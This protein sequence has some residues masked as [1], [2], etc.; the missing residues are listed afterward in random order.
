MRTKFLNIC[1]KIAL[2]LSMLFLVLPGQ[3]QAEERILYFISG[4]EFDEDGT[5]SVT[6]I[7]KVNAEHKNINHGIYRTYPITQVTGTT[8]KNYGFAIQSIKMDGE[9][10]KYSVAYGSLNIGVAI[11]DSNK[12]ISVGQHEYEIKYKTRNHV[13]FGKDRDEINFNVTGN[14]WK[15]PIERASF[16]LVIPGGEDNIL[17]TTAFTGAYGERGTDFV[18]HKKNVIRTTRRLEPGEGFTVA[19]AWKKG[20]VAPSEQTHFDWIGANRELAYGLIFV[21]VL[22]YYFL[23]KWRLMR[24]PNQTIIPLFSPPFGMSPGY[25]AALKAKD[26][27]GRV[28]H[29]DI[30][31]AA[32]NGFLHMDLQNRKN[33]VLHRRKSEKKVSPWINK[34]CDELTCWLCNSEG[35]C[36][37]RTSRGKK[38]AGD[39]FEFLV[40]KYHDR[41]EFAWEDSILTKT[42]GWILIGALMIYVTLFSAHPGLADGTLTAMEFLGFSSMCLV[43]IGIG[44]YATRKALDEREGMARILTI[45]TALT[46]F[47]GGGLVGLWFVACGDYVYLGLSSGVFLLTFWLMKRL[48]GG[49]YTNTGLTEYAKVQGLEM[50][51][52]TAEKHRL[53]KLNAPDDTVEKYEELLPYAIALNCA[54]AWQK[55]FDTLLHD[56]NYE[57]EWVGINVAERD[58]SYS[59]DKVVRRVTVSAS[60]SVAIAASV[61]VSNISSITS[62]PDYSRS[63]SGFTDGGG[64][65]GYSG[66]GSGG[67]GGGGW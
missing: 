22:L 45:A 66:G 20:L 3:V 29:A 55:R 67:G 2:L 37:L 58:E 23:Q 19:A 52:R 48:P 43:F 34:L 24:Q 65:R 64:G 26:Y 14:D 25:M 38:Q 47:T 56:L 28:L 1:I 41:L 12:K 42:F 13:L 36:A 35:E 15:L 51:I 10:V 31:W 54:E 40:R 7:I 53:E 46:L 30:V 32:V 17:E 27:P 59:Y 11:G 60:M 9:P 5:I 57:P 61:A 21:F 6:E 39:A 49:K 8:L 63:S 50:Y 18:R 33:I 44:Y 16:I 62:P 4:V